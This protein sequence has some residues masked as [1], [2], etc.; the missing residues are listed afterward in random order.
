MNAQQEMICMVV[1]KSHNKPQPPYVQHSFKDFALGRFS[2]FFFY[3]IGA[4]E[5]EK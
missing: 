4:Y 2:L 1:I 5:S 3:L